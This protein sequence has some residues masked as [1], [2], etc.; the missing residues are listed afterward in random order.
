MTSGTE[1]LVGGRYLL[2]ELVGQGGMGRVWRGHDQVLD[3]EIAV[4]EVLVPP[5]LPSDERD[6]L[7]ART[8]RE[9][10]SAAR[11]N[12]PG[13]ITIHDVVEHGGVPW[14]VMEYVSGRSLAAEIAAIG[15]LHP[16]RVSR[17]GAKIADA[18]AHAHAAGIIHRDLK[19]DNIL[20]AGD[21]VVISDF[22]IARM[23]N[24]TSVLTSPGTVIGTP[25]YMAPEQLEGHDVGQS[26]DMWALGATLYTAVEG[27]PPFTGPTLATTVAA[28]L[29]RDPE[30]PGHAGDLA[31]VI[32]SLL[33][34]DPEARPDAD[35]AFDAIAAVTPSGVRRAQ[36]VPEEDG[37]EEDGPEEDGPE[38]EGP[39]GEMA[40]PDASGADEPGAGSPEAGQPDAAAHPPT[41]TTASPAARRRA[42]GVTAA[43]RSGS[44][45]GTTRGT[46]PGRPADR[47]RKRL[48]LAGGAV[49]TVAA[50]TI[51]L[52][53]T[54]GNGS[55]H[56]GTSGS[57]SS[58]AGPGSAVGVTGAFGAAPKVSIPKASPGS[59]LFTKAL[60]EGTG[61]PLT[62]T[63]SLVGNFALYDWKGT[64]NK[65]V[66]STYTSSPTLFSGQL[67]PGL[68]KALIGQK[69]GSRVLAVVP[70][71]D[72]FGSAGNPQI[73]VGGTDTLVFVI[74]M[75]AVIG[76]TDGAS[77]AQVS[78]GGGNLPTV[79]VT[80]GKAPTVKVPA[81][82]PPGKLTVKVLAQGTGEKVAKGDYVVVQYTGV[83]W[84]T[85]KVFD[86]SWSRSAPFAFNIGAGQVVKGWDSGL[87]G[88]PAGSR[89]LL[90]VPP[91]EGYGASPPSGS[92]IGKSDT[93][94]FIV[95]ILGAYKPSGAK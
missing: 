13:I 42:T 84:K 40:E 2:V 43:T 62:A 61:K 25:Q 57:S 70:P 28:I 53:L 60:I 10:R 23:V 69:A 39:E 65:L 81:S 3:R 4:K 34:K 27:Q 94:V 58:A 9:A 79:T 90:A 50:V 83:I 16:R 37:P 55:G 71:K 51:A 87:V 77:G 33:A 11:L 30:P 29:S 49:L 56:H 59:A 72:G 75:V 93:M 48:F 19:P 82:A 76:N 18:L 45:R 64:T 52:I 63:A 5:E 73:G 67:L 46:A 66:S 86:S 17:M 6:A 24:S 54:Q 22:G 44:A 91:A 41:V 7:V 21:R 20:L 36:A 80:P 1:A 88:Q 89:V 14:I 78:S 68:E 85:G 95:D 92:G 74:D 47:G 32:A 15:R 8:T 35:S 12:H 31:P 38:G 26:A